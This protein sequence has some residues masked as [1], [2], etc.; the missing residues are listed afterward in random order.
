MRTATR[1]A[2]ASVVVGLGVEAC[3]PSVQPATSARAEAPVS[4]GAVVADA[5]LA[6]AAGDAVDAAAILTLDALAARAT[7][8]AAGM[9]EVAR[10]EIVGDAS[11]ATHVIARADARDV[12]VRVTFGARAPVHASL[13]DARGDVLAEVRDAADATLGAR[14]PVCVR[15]GDV[16]SLRFESSAPLG[17]RFVA[18]ESP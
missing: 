16:V 5:G 18:W 11:G 1:A 6:D 10:G 7:S 8:V 9:R 15:K 12:C 17:A 4:A 3:T 2:W 13:V 14:G